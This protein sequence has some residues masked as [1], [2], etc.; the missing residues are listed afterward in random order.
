MNHPTPIPP[1]TG[2]SS[3]LRR[4]R[5]KHA[6]LRERGADE[7]WLGEPTTGEAVTAFEERN[8]VTLPGSYRAFV[9]SV[10]DGGM[11]FDAAVGAVERMTNV[12]E[13]TY[14]RTVGLE[15]DEYPP[16]HPFPL[17][18]GE[19]DSEG[20]R[21]PHARIE[22]REPWPDDIG[23]DDDWWERAL[24][25]DE[26]TTWGEFPGL[27][28]MAE[29]GCGYAVN[30]VL[31]G[32][33]RGRVLYTW[34]DE[35]P[36]SFP[37]GV[38]FPAW[39]ETWLDMYACGLHFPEGRFTRELRH[40]YGHVLVTSSD[41]LRSWVAERHGQ[42]MRAVRLGASGGR[43]GETGLDG[44]NAEWCADLAVSEADEPTRLAAVCAL[45][46]GQGHPE[47]LGRVARYGRGAPADLARVLTGAASL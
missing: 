40:D 31:Y 13:G 32:P 11:M 34:N 27:L 44:E 4:I 1:G 19:E 41:Y 14:W 46:R 30:L 8:G 16:T 21:Y 3:R 7:L 15:C 12:P 39:Y 26:D 18:A 37:P 35:K 24:D 28:R 2:P 36:P 17:V 38:D 45:S 6:W 9:T 33:E 22:S 10:A 47:W 25:W 5:L 42:A 20:T 43:E 23:F 29:L